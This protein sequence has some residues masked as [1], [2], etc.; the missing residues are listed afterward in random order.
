MGRRIGFIPAAARLADPRREMPLQIYLAES[1]VDVETIGE[2][3]RDYL[4]RFGRCIVVVSE[5]LDVG[6]IGEVKDSFGHTS[7]GSSQLSVGQTVTSYLN[8]PHQTCTSRGPALSVF[9]E[10]TPE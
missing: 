7:Y 9:F 1:G 10:T 8:A 4:G 3:V 5:G 6:E 2:N